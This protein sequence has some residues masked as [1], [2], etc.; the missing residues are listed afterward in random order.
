MVGQ[1]TDV[2]HPA[3]WGRLRQREGLW[4]LAIMLMWRQFVVIKALMILS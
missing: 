1:L 3:I 4:F 2:H